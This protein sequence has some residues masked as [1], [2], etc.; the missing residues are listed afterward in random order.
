MIDKLVRFIGLTLIAGGLALIVFGILVTIL[1]LRVLFIAW[2]V[3]GIL[4]GLS[5]VVHET[6]GGINE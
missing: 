2:G 3:V 4:L 6:G 5:L 1:M